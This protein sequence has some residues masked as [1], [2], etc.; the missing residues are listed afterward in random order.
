[1]R[2][3]PSFPSPRDQAI[4]IFGESGAGKSEATK[5]IMTYLARVTAIDTGTGRGPHKRADV[6]NKD[7]GNGGSLSVGQLEQRVLNTLPCWRRSATPA[8]CATI[9]RPDSESS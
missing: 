2:D 6:E 1:M 5:L 7:G 9:V 4:I 8:L 3:G